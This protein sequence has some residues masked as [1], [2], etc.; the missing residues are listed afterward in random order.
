MKLRSI[1]ILLVLILG[2]S[3]HAQIREQKV[4]MSMGE[5][6]ALTLEIPGVTDK[7]VGEVWKDYLKKEYRSKPK[8]NRKTNEWFSDDA[9]IESLGLGNTIDI[10]CTVEEKGEDVRLNVW[11]D[12]GGAYLNSKDHKDRYTEAEKMLMGFGLEV[13]KEK[14]RI[15]LENEM[16]ELKELEKELAKLKTAN[17]RYHKEIKRAE[18]VIKKAKED[19]VNNEQEQKNMEGQIKEQEKVVK[20]VEKRLSD[21]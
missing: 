7:L 11:F 1:L 4:K 3:L 17:E 9:D 19:I 12:L 10:Y 13:A 16:N 21:L 8:W 5:Q 6:N 20:G 14:T 2:T 15:E 18:E